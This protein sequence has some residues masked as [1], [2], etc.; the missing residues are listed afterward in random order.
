MR[1]SPHFQGIATGLHLALFLTRA[2]DHLLRD[3]LA[4]LTDPA[5]PQPASLRAATRAYQNAFDDHAR[6]AGLAA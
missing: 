4:D 5:P 3:G 1:K 6:H 2:H